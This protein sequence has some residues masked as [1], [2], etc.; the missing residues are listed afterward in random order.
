MGTAEMQVHE[1]KYKAKMID[2]VSNIW[3]YIYANTYEVYCHIHKLYGVYGRS[4]KETVVCVFK[5]AVVRWF[6]L[7]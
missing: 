7:K 1:H 5:G 4:Y 3:K 6:R 2:R